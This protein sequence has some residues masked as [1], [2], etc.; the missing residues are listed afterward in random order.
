ML[1]SV[2]VTAQNYDKFSCAE[3]NDKAMAIYLTNPDLALQLLKKAEIKTEDSKDEHLKGLTINNLAILKRMKGDYLQSKKLSEKATLLSNSPNTKA[4]IANNLGSCNRALGAYKVAIKHYLE[5]L[6][7][8]EGQNKIKEQATVN[9]NIGLVFVDLQQFEKAKKYNNNALELFIKLKDKKG[10]SESYNNIAIVLA[11][12]DSLEKSILFFRKSL[13]IEE[14]LKDKKGIAES[15]NNVGGVHYYLGKIDSAL[16]YFKKSAEIETGLKNFSGVAESYNNI[17]QVYIENKNLESAKQYID[18][19]YNYSKKSKVTADILASLDNYIQYNEANKSFFEANKIIKKYHVIK[20][21]VL[22]ISNLKDINELETKYQT[23]KKEKLILEKEAEN[24]IKTTWLIIISLLTLFIGLIGF[25]I[26]RQQKLKNKQQQQEFQLKSAIAQIETQNQLHEQ[27]LSISRDLHDNIGAQLTFVISSVD[28]LKFGNQ[29]T[30]S[31]I[32]NQLTKISDFTK[33]TIIELRDTIW[34]MNTNE[35]TFEDLRSRIFNFIEKAKSVKEDIRFNFN[36]D[37]SI[38]DM[39]FSSIIGINLYRV[40]Q[41]A[42]NNALKYAE[43]T[44]IEVKVIKQNKQLVIEIIDNGN[45]FDTENVEYGNGLQ[46]MKKRIDEVDG[47]F[48]INSTINKGTTISIL[49]SK[50]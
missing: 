28:N 39:K 27:R 42:V 4:S 1:F 41:E 32:T 34:A 48:T 19:A 47:T 38:K 46:N 23:A 15:L 22:K 16:F 2:S 25:L 49:L 24:K 35:F 13:K 21:S 44:E 43:A 17:A 45:G 29:I 30:D 31:K 18:S 6:K 9:N 33:S 7:Y 50:I 26:Y 5:A 14:S 8:Y 12:Q 40:I 3:L 37:D 36:V 10:L 20:D 11:N